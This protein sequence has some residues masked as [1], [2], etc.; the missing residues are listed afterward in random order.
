MYL[1]QSCITF[2][3]VY[4]KGS[5]FLFLLSAWAVFGVCHELV[6]GPPLLGGLGLP[7]EGGKGWVGFST[8]F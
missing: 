6:A 2:C 8:C 7:R 5:C 4:N 3:T 1:L